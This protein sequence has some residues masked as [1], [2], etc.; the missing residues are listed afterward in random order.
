MPSPPLFAPTSTGSANR[1]NM[2]GDHLS[3]DLPISPAATTTVVAPY[4][5]SV[6]DVTPDRSKTDVSASGPSE[7]VVWVEKQSNQ[8]EFYYY[9]KQT[10]ETS[11]E[12]PAALILSASGRVIDNRQKV[13]SSDSAV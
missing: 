5:N 11:W 6:G 9:H 1:N 2:E 12:P 3:A 4:S 10:K 7:D 13:N 8:G